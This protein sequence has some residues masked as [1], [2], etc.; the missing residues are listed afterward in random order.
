MVE[1]EDYE[2]ESG[3]EYVWQKGQ[4]CPPGLRKSQKRRVQRL[5]NKELKEAVAQKTEWCLKKK[6]DEQGPSADA[7]MTY[8][9]PLEFMAPGDQDVQ[10]EIYSNFDETEF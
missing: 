8:F 5:R 3:H 9:L 4:W 1:Y 6:P 10:E 2:E 7:C